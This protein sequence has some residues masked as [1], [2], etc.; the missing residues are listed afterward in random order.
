MVFI[1]FLMVLFIGCSGL[2]I[3]LCLLNKYSDLIWKLR[4]RYLLR[5]LSVCCSDLRLF[6]LFLFLWL[7]ILISVIILLCRMFLKS[8]ICCWLLIWFFCCWSRIW[9]LDFWI[10]IVD[11]IIVIVNIIVNRIVMVLV[12]KD[13][14]IFI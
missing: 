10:R 13:I 1:S 2:L 7:M 9:V 5:L 6:V 3:M 8:W 11:I 4:V 12:V 14:W